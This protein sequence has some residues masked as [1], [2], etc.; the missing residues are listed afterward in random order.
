MWRLLKNF[1]PEMRG[2][3]ALSAATGIG[4]LAV[5]LAMAFNVSSSVNA[6]SSLQS[7]ADETAL[8][9]AVEVNI[10]SQSNVD[11]NSVAL[12]RV[13]AVLSHRGQP[14]LQAGQVTVRTRRTEPI[15][16]ADNASP[17][18]RVPDDTIEVSIETYPEPSPAMSALNKAPK[19]IR[20]SASALRL[21]SSNLCVIA[22]H[23]AFSETLSMRDAARMTAP[24][25]DIISNST[26]IDGL[27][28]TDAAKLTGSDIH[29]AGG[30]SGQA[31]NFSPD[32]TTDSLMM[33]DPLAGMPEPATTPC[34]PVPKLANK[35]NTPLAPGIY[36]GGLKLNGHRSATL[37]NGVYTFHG[38]VDV[39]K[40]GS[41]FANGATIHL[42]SNGRF[43]ATDGS[44]L[45]MTAP[46]TGATAG[47]LLFESPSANEGNVHRIE[48]IDARYMVGT[49]YIPR[50]MFYVN[51]SAPVADQSEYTAIVVRRLLLEGNS[52]LVLNTDYAA[53]PVP[54]PAGVGPIEGSVR[55]VD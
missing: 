52:N 53:T 45:R 41:L 8:A 22:L 39:G 12:A 25:C 23:A 13:N 9:L 31:V 47:I 15:S 20:V 17:P 55:L 32:P 14:A 36:C 35:A 11:L 28:V 6:R 49:I 30:A 4:A 24:N 3:L 16:I 48:T 5:L 37:S 26:A 33:P 38:D 29:S 54:T 46:V 1:V 42:A 40:N 50:G 18:D 51:A 19:P 44:T 27:N 34:I 43:L 21:G 10:L 7:I 2:Q